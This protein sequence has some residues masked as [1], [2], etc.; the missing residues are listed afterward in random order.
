MNEWG[1]WVEHFKGERIE[2][3]IDDA[4]HMNSMQMEITTTEK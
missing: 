3:E 1:V 4:I 2:G